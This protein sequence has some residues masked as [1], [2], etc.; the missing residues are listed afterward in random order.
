MEEYRI[1]DKAKSLIGGWFI[2]TSMCDMLIDEYYKNSKYASWDNLRKYSRLNDSQID[3]AVV[4]QYVV[5]LKSCI[6]MYKDKYYWCVKSNEP[7]AITQPI[8]LQLFKPGDAYSLQHIESGGPQKGKLQRHLTFMTYLNDVN[9]GGQTEFEY[10]N[11]LV[12]PKKGLT[13]VWPAV[14]THPHRGIP[15]ISEDKFIMTGWCSF[16]HRC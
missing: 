3:T 11:I 13:L 6:E 7:W 1:E 10:Q 14:W 2:D 4:E 12:Q 15:A 9:D 8:N 5:H 16:F